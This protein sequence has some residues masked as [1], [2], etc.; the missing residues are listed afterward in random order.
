MTISQC[1][2]APRGNALGKSISPSP[3][4]CFNSFPP[5]WK[6]ESWKVVLTFHSVVKMCRVAWVPS[7]V[8]SCFFGIWQIK[9]GNVVKFWLWQ[10]LGV[11][12]LIPKNLS[13][14]RTFKLPP[15]CMT[16][17]CWV[18]RHHIWH[19]FPHTDQ[20]M[21]PRE[22]AA[23]RRLRSPLQECSIHITALPPEMK[24]WRN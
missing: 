22:Y 8:I 18:W 10:L 6:M 12:R 15:T 16:Y 13:N 17:Q 1:A 20:S 23:W 11:K 7:H 2:K 14:Y 9:F 19:V 3:L 5:E 4:S 24:L 21:C